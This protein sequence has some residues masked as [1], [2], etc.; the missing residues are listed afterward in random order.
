NT[1]LQMVPH[2]GGLA[3]HCYTGDPATMK[4]Y[5]NV[6]E[7]M[8]ECSNELPHFPAALIIAEAFRDN[9]SIASVWNVALQP[10][11]G[12]VQPPDK[13]CPGCF[14]VA[15]VNPETHTYRYTR[16][17]YQLGQ[18]SHFIMRGAVRL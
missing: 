18:L 14:G 12:P 4:L 7:I 8:D 10:G 5:P 3:W 6:N 15:T 11:G 17:Y 1:V 9:V 13:G 16:R 2:L